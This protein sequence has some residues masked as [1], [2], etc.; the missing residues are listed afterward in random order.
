M[1]LRWI[2]IFA[3]LSV[4]HPAAAETLFVLEAPVGGAPFILPDG[5][6]ACESAAGGWS[7]TAGNVSIK[8]PASE[9]A[10]GKV[11]SLTVGKGQSECWRNASV[12]LVATRAWPRFDSR[13]ATLFADEGRLEVQGRSLEG[14]RI[15]WQTPR[16]RGVELC[17]TN[18]DAT[19]QRDTCAVAVERGLGAPPSDLKLAWVPAGAS[20]A[21]ASL[22]FDAAGRLASPEEFSL[23]PAR[24]VV[25]RLL[26]QNL[27]LDVSAGEARLP[28]LHPE[29]VQAVDCAPASCEIGD[30]AV[31]VRALPGVSRDLTIRLRLAP[32]V[33]MQGGGDWVTTVSVPAK[34]TFCP[35]SIVS[36]DPLRDVEAAELVVR[37]DPRCADRARSLA[38]DINGAPAEVMSVDARADAIYAVLR[39]GRLHGSR[40]TVAAHRVG[41]DN[42]L[43]AIA[44]APL[45]DAPRFASTLELAGLGRIDFI[46]TN[47]DARLSLSSPGEE[48][49]IV[50]LSLPGAY[51]VRHTPEGAKLR[52]LASSGGFVAL[53]FG[54]RIPTL[55]PPLDTRDLA[56][57]TEPIQRPLREANVPAPFGSSSTGDA[58][59]IELVCTGK[60]DRPFRVRPGADVHVPFRHRNGCRLRVHRERIPP[61]DGEQRIALSVSVKTVS[62]SK[63]DGGSLEQILIL[64]HGSESREFWLHGVEDHYDRFEVRAVHVI[65]ESQYQ[66]TRAA[67]LEAPAAQWNVI[68]ESARAR[69]YATATIPA[70]LYR[71]SRDPEDAGSGPL[72]LN[73]GVLSRLTLLDKNGHES[74]LGLETGVMGMGLSTDRERQ[75][76][77]VAGLG[78]GV[79]IANASQPSQAAI[80]VHAWVAYRV[81]NKSAELESGEV[82]ELSP[83]AFVFG[84]SITIGSVGA[85]L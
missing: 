46:P 24:V 71:F 48:A 68:V 70:S 15:T 64:R 58:P 33:V 56:V 34:L 2:V 52:G 37:L 36:G 1:W 80:N 55:P 62:G 53:R 61:E 26:A 76:N 47:R 45:R 82:V 13:T 25:S 72:A 8:P 44:D 60:D 39:A 50:A 41:Q 9:D 31:V 27:V 40:V 18:T 22:R 43:V 65:D 35:M 14:A 11:L 30:G 29:A 54:Y 3:V 32:R 5:L 66:S 79:P 10:V 20:E 83:W 38:Y 85:N 6:V 23:V 16:G 4:V 42:T 84:P 73:F 78:V 57:L 19:T 63:R 28:L 17:F 74:L 67:P 12:Q 75:L 69:F 81:G 21:S 77:L 49:R 7:S 51:E 59:L